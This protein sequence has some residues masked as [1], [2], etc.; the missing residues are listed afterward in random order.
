MAELTPALPTHTGARLSWAQFRAIAWLRW[1]ILANSFRRKGGAGELIGRIL[2]LPIAAGVALA[3]T[4]L[5]G[6]FAWAAFAG[7]SPQHLSLV[8]W[9]AFAITQL[10][11]L[12]LGQPG[13]T[14]DPTELIR[15]PVALP[16]YVLVRLCFGLLSP[17]NLIVT[18]MSVA[19]FVGVTIARPALWPWT[20]AATAAFALA[21]VLF[22]R[23]I[24]AWI[25]R[26]LSTRR[27]R[28]LF[29]GFIFVGSLALQYLNVN[30]NPGFNH[31]RSHGFTPQRLRSVQTALDH[32]HPW[33]RWLPPE[34]TSAS[35]IAAAR[36]RF[37]MSVL[38]VAL[39]LAYAT[40]FLLAYALRMRTEYRG[41]N[42]S[43]AANAVRPASRRADPAR[44]IALSPGT[45]LRPNAAT[46]SR[47]W[48]P[49]SFAPL[50]RKELLYLRRNTGLLY[51]V[52]APTVMVFLFAGRLSMRGGS[53]WILLM[54]VS[55]ALLGL[56]P[57][58][59]NTFGLEGPGAQFYFM[60]PVP[61]RDVFL[62]KNAM[63]FLLAMVEVCAVIAIVIYVTG[64][65]QVDDVL[66]VLLWATATLLLNTSLGNLRSLSAPKKVN[67]G[68]SLNRAQSQVSAWIA[69]GLLAGSGGV[70]A[71]LQFLSTYLHL[72]WL[73]LCLMGAFAVGGLVAYT[74]GL[75]GIEAYAMDHRDTL[76]EEL[77][78]KT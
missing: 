29:T 27:A 72:R 73:G 48:L 16:S 32:L 62:A 61:M 17:A 66:F 36:G 35:I 3:P 69:I 14:F 10:F 76:F 1:R 31:G 19:V 63:Q 7:G 45:E 68:R 40:V 26:W 52:V 4:A 12:N 60:A 24:F 21:N 41:E 58:S 70:G 37:Q 28:E 23:L 74:Q 22:S 50:F 56:A 30:Y 44:T 46:Q 11:N 77:G 18:L 65:P 47:T 49:G 39:V 42:L 13:T 53:H 51:G 25:D 20:L 71:G 43:D 57:M 15:F 78:K 59:Y 64:T 5:A 54:A 8:L 6:F 9:G 55:Y 67:P 34:L 33:L 38:D 2:V 75:R